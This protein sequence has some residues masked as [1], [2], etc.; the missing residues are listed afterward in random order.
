MVSLASTL[1][2]HQGWRAWF[3]NGARHCG[4]VQHM[5]SAASFGKSRPGARF[6][7]PAMLDLAGGMESAVCISG[8]D[9][10]PAKT[11]LGM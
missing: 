9:S 1:G 4:S 3:L 7:H 10:A 11:S 6:V 2:R 8:T 5:H